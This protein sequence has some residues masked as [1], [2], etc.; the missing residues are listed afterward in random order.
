MIMQGGRLFC[1]ADFTCYN[2]VCKPSV[3][4]EDVLRYHIK[5]GGAFNDAPPLKHNQSKYYAV[6]KLKMP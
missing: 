1:N 5:K 3:S 2:A 6:I 4:F